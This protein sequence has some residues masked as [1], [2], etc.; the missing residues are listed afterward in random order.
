MRLRNPVARRLT[1]AAVVVLSSSCVMTVRLVPGADRVTLTE[2]AS[3][4]A[5]CKVVGNVSGLMP[6]A[7]YSSTPR[8]SFA[9]EPWASTG[10]PSFSP[11]QGRAW[12]TAARDAL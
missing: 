3:D 2:N 11:R 4:V 10:T 12:L 1:L 8:V 5:G 6:S 9:I 7:T